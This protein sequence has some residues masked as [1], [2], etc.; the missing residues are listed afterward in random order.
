M[1]SSK[2]EQ[3][4]SNALSR[5]LSRRIQWVAAAA[6][7]VTGVA[8]LGFGWTVSFLAVFLIIA[9]AVS[10][11]FPRAGGWF[12]VLPALVLSVIVLPICIANPVELLKALFL[13]PHDFNFLAMSIS[14]LLS[15]I[16]L[17]WCVTAV[18]TKLR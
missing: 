4:P 5:I 17:I 12:I 11:R 8:L 13:G 9:A 14:W 1:T 10:S 2:E 6:G 7:C 3:Y 16:L 15:P 18:M